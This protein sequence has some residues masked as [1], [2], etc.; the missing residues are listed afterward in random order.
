LEHR[1]VHIHA[2]D[3]D[4]AA[5]Q[6][7][8]HPSAAAPGIEHPRRRE[9]V[10]EVGLAVHVHPGRGQ[11]VEALLVVLAVPHTDILA[12]PWQPRKPRGSL[13]TAPDRVDALRAPVVVA[14]SGDRSAA[15][16]E[17]ERLSPHPRANPLMR[18]TPLVLAAATLLLV[19]AVACTPRDTA[20]YD[21]L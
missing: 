4:A 15:G 12:A 2:G 21:C 7:D 6:L 14:T 17:T 1:G 20:R 11:V 8:G 3:V 10:D 19:V 16:P 5:R 18:R 9:G 13:K